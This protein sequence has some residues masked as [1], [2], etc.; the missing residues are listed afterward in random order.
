MHFEPIQLH[1]VYGMTSKKLCFRRV[2]VLLD[3]HVFPDNRAVGP[4][5]LQLTV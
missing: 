3:D 5:G 1:F 4:D 2:S